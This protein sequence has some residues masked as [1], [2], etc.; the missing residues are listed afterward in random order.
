MMCAVTQV[1]K[2]ETTLSTI[3]LPAISSAVSKHLKVNAVYTCINGRYAED[4]FADVVG[5][6]ISPY[7]CHLSNWGVD[8]ETLE[9]WP[10]NI[11]IRYEPGSPSASTPPD[12][13]AAEK[14]LRGL[15]PVIKAVLQTEFKNIELALV[16]QV[17]TSENL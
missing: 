12:P 16:T 3:V 17:T 10:V 9:G 1:A 7:S 2:E 6:V 8:D 15:V 11:S 14:V 5:E 13:G 4:H